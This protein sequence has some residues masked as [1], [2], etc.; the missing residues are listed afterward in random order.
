MDL[1]INT[2]LIIE[3][4]EGL[5]ELLNEKITAC[6]YEAYYVNSATTAIKWLE[7]Q[8]PFMLIL[9]YSL[10]DMNGKEFVT[11]LK[12][13]GV[14]LPP[15]IV[16]T[17]QGD[18]RIAVE[19]MKLGARDYIIKDSH[20]LDMIPIV[21]AKAGREIENENKLRM[22]EQALLESNQFNKQIIQS[23]HEGIVV[24][25]IDLK[26]KLWNPFMEQLTGI[27]ASEVLGKYPFQVF[28]FLK[29]SG[30]V[31]SIENALKGET[32]PEID[33][34]FE[35]PG[36]GKSGWTSDTTAPIYNSKGE[37]I[38]AITTVRD[39]TER[40]HAEEV[41]RKSREDFKESETKYRELVENS[42][43][44]IAIYKEGKVAFINKECLRLM[45]AKSTKE[46]M[47]MS[48]MDFVHP[49]SR[50]LVIERMKKAAINNSAL[51][52][53]EEKFIRLDGTEV[54]VEVKAMTISFEN[55]PAVQLIVRDITERKQAQLLLQKKNEEYVQLNEELIQTNE[56]LQL[57]KEHAEES[58][59]LKTAFLANMSHEIRTPMNGIL[60]FADLLKKPNLSD[61]KQQKYISVIEKSGARMLN[62]IND[63][64][65]IS[66]IE[67]GLMKIS[68][69][70]T[71]INE[72]NEFIYTFFKPEVDRK[73]LS[74]SYKN[75]LPS[76]KAV[77]KTDREKIYAVLTNVVKNAVKYS[78]TGSIELGY[79][80]IPD[81]RDKACLVSTPP[82]IEFYVKDTGIGIPKDRQGAIFERFIQADIADKRAFQGAGL[83][84]AI[85]K[86][87]IE[88]LGGKIWV[89]S[90]PA[91]GSV[92]Y[93]TLPY[94]CI[95]DN[96]FSNKRQL[97][98]DKNENKVKGLKILI[99]ED[100][101]T[102][103]MLLSEWIDAFGK[104]ILYVKT[105][106]EAVEICRKNPDLDLILMDIQ[107]P[108]MD[109]YEATTKI[110]QFNKNI[111]IVAQTAFAL[112]GEK[113]K[114]IEA[115][116]NDYISKPIRKNLLLDIINQ[117][118]E[119]IGK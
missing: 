109:G 88:M 117:H 72:L 48:V 95:N 43:D 115:G 93:F 62:I 2:I 66:K 76:E 32:V 63:I 86:A 12:S 64:V 51:P 24:Y 30:A 92:F 49:D 80:L 3:D 75:F 101:E 105:G 99:A 110:R 69:S 67:S 23:A 33:L 19:M 61:E 111:I 116:C 83:G 14:F 81:D 8:M 21:I 44:A 91:K 4:D 20:F 55:K 77:I 27:S 18:E 29:N 96:V 9:D 36:T 119:S 94:N 26:Y 102:S 41:L 53:A 31:K 39:I 106:K 89:E 47:G 73:G 84:L 58:D 25:D 10:P 1:N 68:I 82:Q 54:D 56:E 57:A 113:E 15:F 46:L 17:G 37:I 65:D 38:G 5:V 22:A 11:E 104:N 34:Q 28:P 100:D 90:E 60:G 112:S 79:N 45:K 103:V 85:S 98:E 35:I 108:V 13:R 118:F 50:Q 114:A 78:D 87:Y 52:L 74:I 7:K 42:P 71:N 97:S 107:M 40:K 6:G 70:E 59:R 16:S